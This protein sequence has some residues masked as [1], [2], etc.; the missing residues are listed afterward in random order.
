MSGEDLVAAVPGLKDVRIP[1]LK[2]VSEVEVEVEQFSNIPGDYFTPDLWLKLS[3]RVNELLDR[4]DVSGLVITHGTDTME[5]TAFFLDLTLQSEKPVVLTGAQ[6]NASEPDADGPCNIL[7]SVRVAASPQ[8]KNKGV[9]IC[10]NGQI[11]SA[12]YATK[13]HT[14]GVET[15]Q[16]GEVGFLGVVTPTGITFYHEPLYRRTFKV[17]RVEPVVDIIAAYSGI[18]SRLI[19]AAVGSG[20]GGVVV[21]AMGIGNLSDGIYDGIVRAI[22]KGVPVVIST[23][24]HRG[25]V[26][27]LYS[28]QG[29]GKSTLEAGAIFAGDLSPQKARILLMI[30][31]G[32]T[33][34]LSEIRGIFEQMG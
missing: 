33:R 9:M 23:R 12:R 30:A 18:D 5:E 22:R 15:F 16:S 32:L 34:D 31:L 1:G 21:Q 8:A 24:V 14:Y 2:D 3:R 27:P 29:G 28:F 25:R 13:T 19:D 26:V 4:S 10:L 17:E 20:A 7:D 6:R 11:N